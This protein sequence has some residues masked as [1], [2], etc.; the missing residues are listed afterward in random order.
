MEVQNVNKTLSTKRGDSDPKKPSLRI[1]VAVPGVSMLDDTTPNLASPVVYKSAAATS[2]GNTGAAA[3]SAGLFYRIAMP[4]VITADYSGAAADPG[5]NCP[6]SAIP[7][8]TPVTAVVPDSRAGTEVGVDALAG[9]LT[10]TTIGLTFTN[11]MFTSQS[12]QRPSELLAFV[13]IPATIINEY[14][15]ILTNFLQLRVNY[16]TAEA[17]LVTQQAN[18][19]AA[20]ITQ[21]QN[22][23]QLAAAG[24]TA[25]AKSRLAL[26][27]LI[28]QLQTIKQQLANPP[29]SSH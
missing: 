22:A 4:V 10:T 29:T 19:L 5:S 9:L 3:T 25:D 2:A 16:A 6:L 27:Q 13:G 26:L 23:A 7:Q 8:V 1:D 15:T 12:V 24:P 20:Q 11:G 28:Q 21:V 18:I 14:T 17:N